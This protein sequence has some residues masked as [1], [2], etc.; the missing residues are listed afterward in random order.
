MMRDT[1]WKKIW[2]GVPY[3][4]FLL[5][6]ALLVVLVL[7]PLVKWITR[8]GGQ[9]ALPGGTPPGRILGELKAE[10]PQGMLGVGTTPRDQV[11]Q[12]ANSDT[13]HFAELLSRWINEE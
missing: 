3:L 5:V 7:R 2:K 8:P 13:K 10:G 4:V 6:V 1:L 9:A 11:A 12:I